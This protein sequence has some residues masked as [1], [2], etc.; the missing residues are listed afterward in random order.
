ML[1]K[2]ARII[3]AV[4]IPMV[5]FAAK[6]EKDTIN[7]HVVSAKTKIHGSAPREAFSY[8]DIMF[9]QVNGK[10]VVYT[11][12]QRGDVCPV[13]ESGK[14]YTVDR[15]GDFILLPMTFAENKKPF[16]AKYKQ[17]GGW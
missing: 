12:D 13:L 1:N 16:F 11:C 6:K 5:A 2:A 8:T 4:L 10:N 17:A 14:T 3:F 15:E 9:A 7:I